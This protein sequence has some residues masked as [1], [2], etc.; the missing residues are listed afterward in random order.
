MK[1]RLY[2]FSLVLCLSVTVT[3]LGAAELRDHDI[4][5]D[6]YFNLSYLPESRISP[7]GKYV[8]YA[9]ARWQESTDDRKADVWVVKTDTGETKRLTS[10]RAGDRSLLWSPDSQYVYFAGNRSREGVTLPPY[11]GT[12]QVWRVS[13]QGGEP[14]AETR[15]PGGIGV[16]DLTADGQTLYYT[17][18]HPSSSDEWSAL[19][20]RFAK[21]RYGNGTEVTTDVNKLDLRNWRSDIKASLNRAVSELSLAPDESHLAV[22]TAPEDAVESFEGSSRVE[23][24]TLPDGKLEAL[25]DKLWRADA[26]SKYGRLESLT[27]SS[28]GRALSFIIAFDGYPSEIMVARFTAEIPTLFAVKRPP[29]VSLHA[30]VGTSLQMHWRKES[31]ELC[32][33]GEE[34]GRNRVYSA[35]QIGP[36]QM[37]EYRCIT[38]GDVAVDS[39]SIDSS[40]DHIAAILGDPTHLPEVCVLTSSGEAKRLT[41]VNPQTARWKFPRISIAAWKGANEIPVEGILEIPADSTPGQRLP[42]I[43][44]VHGGPTYSNSYQL[45]YDI[46]GHILYSSHGYAVLSP[47]YRGST[48]YGDDFLEGLLGHENDIE[49]EDILKGVDALIERGIVDPYRI[50]VSGWSNGGYITNCLIAKTDRF[51]AASSGASI[52]DI[53]VEWTANDEPA[54]P[55]AFVKGLPWDASD[56]YVKASP[57]FHFGRTRTPTIFH[58]GDNDPRCP[59]VNS[60]ALYRALKEY[61]AVPTELLIYPQEP[62]TLGHYSSRKA[63]MAWDIAWFDR[64]IKGNKNER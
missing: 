11:D 19:R 56:A 44:A 50:G 63:K 60:L 41:D 2:G 13:V 54:Y 35:T 31:S 9:E 5:L 36:N 25:D 48:G 26:P 52:A 62:H 57:I 22:V 6:D 59:K 53:L 49:V 3:S 38:P 32:F 47:N 1:R 64:Y 23:V 43:V 15:V 58:V 29:G 17:T 27:W 46:Y 16:F 42:L 51:R 7:D 55:M 39:F 10:D 40:G 12:T 61:L 37:P 33:I 45:L 4:T 28:D 24:M 8:A 14:E 18:T 30:D 34:K 20:G 21:V